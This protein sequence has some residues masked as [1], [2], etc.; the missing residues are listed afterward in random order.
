MSV[1]SRRSVFWGVAASI[2]LASLYALIVGGAS[3]SLRH[4]LDQAQTDW[5]LL[6]PLMLG[7][8]LQIALVLELRRRHRLQAA[9]ATA[10]GA[11]AGASTVGM[12]A[13][14]AHHVADLAPFIGATGA[15]TF[16]I[17]YRLPFIIGGLGITAVGVAVSAR[18][19]ARVAQAERQ[20]T[21]ACVA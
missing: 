12:V 4:L 7:F 6:T 3:R 21:R 5:Y 9:T 14:C 1:L 18:R 10:G 20:E 15:A 17:E 2:G 16:L 11:G 13:C 8:G 19:L